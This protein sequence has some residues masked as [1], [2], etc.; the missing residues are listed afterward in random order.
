MKKSIVIIAIISVFLVSLSCGKA[1]VVAANSCEKAAEK[2]TAAAQVFSSDPTNKTK[3][4]AYADA[5]AELLKDCP[6]FYTGATKQ[7]LVDFQKTACK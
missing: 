6:T 5:I 7:A 1:A 4:Q 3:C 2:V